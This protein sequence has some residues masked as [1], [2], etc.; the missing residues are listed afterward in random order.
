MAMGN[1]HKKF[2]E[3]WPHGV[4]VM[5]G[6]RSFQ[7]TFIRR[8]QQFYQLTPFAITAENYTVALS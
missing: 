1:I 7:K 2:G 3:V 8:H 5:R 6:Y 4:R